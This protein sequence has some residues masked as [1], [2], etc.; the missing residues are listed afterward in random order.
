MIS[1]QGIKH[2]HIN[3]GTGD[4][5]CSSVRDQDLKRLTIKSMVTDVSCSSVLHSNQEPDDSCRY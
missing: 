4:T 2:Q 1:S 3:V 5:V